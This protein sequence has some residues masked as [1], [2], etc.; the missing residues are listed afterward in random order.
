MSANT[1]L[2]TDASRLSTEQ[3]VDNYSAGVAAH[4]N[5]DLSRHIQIQI[6]NQN[7]VDSCGNTIPN[8]QRLRLLGTFNGV[9]V[10]IVLPLI[11]AAGAASGASPSITTQPV[12]QAVG[13]GWSIGFTVVATGAPVL[14]YQWRR[15]GVAIP[16]AI[17]PQL[18]L[19]NIQ[20]NDEG[21]YDCVVSNSQGI[22]FS[23]VANLTVSFTVQISQSSGGFFDSFLSIVTL[24]LG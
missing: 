16:G 8:S 10:A 14:R 6:I 23:N 4:I 22:T 21:A 18:A 24:G 15:N 11:P 9:D 12:S 3:N 19:T 17:S 5:G 20:L 2:L 1:P 7:W 13:I